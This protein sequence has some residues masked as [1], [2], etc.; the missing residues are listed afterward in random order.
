MAKL[1]PLIPRVMY[2]RLG[3]VVVLRIPAHTPPEKAEAAKYQAKLLADAESKTTKRRYDY[4][5]IRGQIK[6]F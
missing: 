2:S 4:K 3:T 6:L 1:K 5:K